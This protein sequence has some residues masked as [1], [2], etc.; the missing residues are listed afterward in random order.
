MVSSIVVSRAEGSLKQ[1][2]TILIAG[3]SFLTWLASVLVTAHGDQACLAGLGPQA[4]W[5]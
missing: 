3:V 5:C 1:L 2:W 4:L